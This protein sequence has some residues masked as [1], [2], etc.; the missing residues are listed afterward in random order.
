MDMKHR[1]VLDTLAS[2]NLNDE[3]LKTLEG[4]ARDMAA[5]YVK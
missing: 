5:K 4:V 3:L 2:G 1:D